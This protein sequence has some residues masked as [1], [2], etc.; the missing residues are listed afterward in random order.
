MESERVEDVVSLF[1]G[2]QHPNR[3]QS[4]RVC[5]IN[6]QCLLISHVLLTESNCEIVA[7]KEYK[8]T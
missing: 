5:E 7:T 3:S 2:E 1:T 4:Q 6:I 8:A